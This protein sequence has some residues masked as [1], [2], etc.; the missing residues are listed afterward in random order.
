LSAATFVVVTDLALEAL[1][2]EIQGV[3]DV[4]TLRVSTVRL[5]GGGRHGLDP[6]DPA[7]SRVLLDD[8]LDLQASEPWF[9]AFQARKLVLGDLPEALSYAVPP[10][11]EDEFH[12]RSSGSFLRL[13]LTSPSHRSRLRAERPASG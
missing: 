10:A 9:D 3:V 13:V 8:H 6:M 2:D 1:G 7:L 12:L 4:L 5:A 11:L